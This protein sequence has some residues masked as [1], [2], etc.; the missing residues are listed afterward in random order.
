MRLAIV[1][2]TLSIAVG[3][4]SAHESTQAPV[5]QR[6]EALR[7]QLAGETALSYRLTADVRSLKDAVSRGRVAEVRQAAIRARRDSVKLR[8]AA[9]ALTARISPLP[10]TG[11]S[12]AIQRT[13][14]VDQ[15]TVLAMQ[16][17]EGADVAAIAALLWRDPLLM[18]PADIARLRRLQAR[19]GSAA[20]HAVRA[21][22][23][24]AALRRDSPG[25]F[26]YVPVR[27]ATGAPRTQS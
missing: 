2:A 25:S 18:S 12:H 15:L 22:R 16:R 27:E 1:L 6:F 7:G 21:S 13:F 14:L 23:S 10:R 5:W 17:V 24:A 3:G 11:R 9:T 26:R 19:A 8:S 4:C 20:R